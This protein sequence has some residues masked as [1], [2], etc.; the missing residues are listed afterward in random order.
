MNFLFLTALCVNLIFLVNIYKISKYINIHDIPDG[1]RKIHRTK[2]PLV[3]G[4]IFIYNLFIFL[5]FDFFF[6]LSDGNFFYERNYFSLY[7]ISTIIF[8]LGVYDD[9]FDMKPNTKIILI[10]IIL[11]VSVLVN[12]NLLINELQFTSFDKNIPLKNFS[13]FFTIFCIFIFINAFN[14]FD[15]INLQSGLYTVV[16]FSFFIFKNLMVVFSALFL[17]SSFFFLYLNFKNKTFLG[18]G[19][20]NLVSYLISY[21]LIIDYNINQKIFLEEILVLM[22]IPGLDMLRVF[23]IR[24]SRGKNPFVADKNHIHHLI[25]KKLNN[26]Q[27]N[28][29]LITLVVTPILLSQIKLIPLLYSIVIGITLYI[30]TILFFTKLK[31]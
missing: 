20:S 23:I 12:E 24:V 1:K 25:I 27:A 2:V 21:F 22:L 18:N 17:L 30:S 7:F 28:I 6:N 29:I 14:M 26:I 3:G 10:T 11:L 13:V 4:V 9:K 19:G 5:F 16:I 8:L 31:K 15:G